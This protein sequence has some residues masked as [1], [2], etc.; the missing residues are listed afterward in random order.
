MDIYLKQ[1]K[2]E[3]PDYDFEVTYVTPYLLINRENEINSYCDISDKKHIAV[4]KD[5]HILFFIT[6][7]EDYHYNGNNPY[8]HTWFVMDEY[9]NG[10]YVSSDFHAETK[11]T[12]YNWTSIVQET[13]DKFNKYYRET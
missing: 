9:N 12:K 10:A 13:I 11:P 7:T 1:L 8:F 3:Y 5:N 6:L 4:I 2:D